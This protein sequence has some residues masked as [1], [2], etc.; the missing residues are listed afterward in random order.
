MLDLYSLNIPVEQDA[1]IPLN[2]VNVAKGCSTTHGAPSSVE[3]NKC[4]VYM[5]SCSASIT[6]TATGDVSIAL[7]RNG[8][9]VP[10]ISSVATTAAGEPAALSFL[11]LIQVRDNN[12]CSCCSS[13]TTLQLFNT[14]QVGIA[15]IVRMTVTKV[16]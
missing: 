2:N 5:V 15:P 1:S 11:T 16:C 8:V 13:P 10:G 9:I 14:G 12:T 7:A 4:G 3:L 6:P